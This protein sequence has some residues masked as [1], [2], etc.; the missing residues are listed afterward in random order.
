MGKDKSSSGGLGRALVR[1]HNQMVQQSK[2]KGAA[3]RNLHG[4]Y[5][6]PIESITEVTDIDAVV[7]L[8]AAGELYEPF[9][10]P[11]TGKPP[12]AAISL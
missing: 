7:E 5:K 10:Q 8:A 1:R 2:E 3:A 4:R 12:T 6:T 11:G 9:E